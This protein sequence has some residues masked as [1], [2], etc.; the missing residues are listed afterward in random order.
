MM[1]D[2]KGHFVASGQITSLY[3]RT[4]FLVLGIILRRWYFC[5]SFRSLTLF[6]MAVKKCGVVP[7]GVIYDSQVIN[8]KQGGP[9]REPPTPLGHSYWLNGSHIWLPAGQNTQKT[10]ETG[11]WSSFFI[12]KLPN[13]H[14]LINFFTR[15][16]SYTFCKKRSNLKNIFTSGHW[17]ISLLNFGIYIFSKPPD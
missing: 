4:N 9:L 14:L 7:L 16:T 2:G 3:H 17:V 10:S 6:W 5:L 12:E 1:L 11:G 8:R 15:C 13:K